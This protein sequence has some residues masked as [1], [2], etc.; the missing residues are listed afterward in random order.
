MWWPSRNL[1]VSGVRGLGGRIQTRGTVVLVVCA[2]MEVEPKVLVVDVAGD[3]GDGDIHGGSVQY[4]CFGQRGGGRGVGVTT[5]ELVKKVSW[6][7][8]S[9]SAL[10]GDDGE[11]AHEGVEGAGEAGNT[12]GG[13]GWWR[14]G[15]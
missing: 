3:D 4:G 7:R 12:D 11:M 14:H 15:S 6:R 13:L 9:A 1:Q 2:P 10:A 8:W 5:P